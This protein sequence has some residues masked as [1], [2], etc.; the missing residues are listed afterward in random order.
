M[1]RAMKKFGILGIAICSIFS[2]TLLAQNGASD[3]TIMTVDGK[4]VPRSE[5]EAIYKKNN[6]ETVVTQKALDEYLDLFINYKLK[7]REAE[8]LGM[9]TISKF[10]T[11]LDGYRKQLS[12]PYLIDRELNDALMKEA[13][14]R[15]QQ[16]IRA[17][18][19]LLQVAPDASPEDTLVVYK[20]IVALRDRIVKGE[21]FASIAQ[22][23]G[24]SEDPSA[25]KNGGDLGWFSAL[26]MVYPFESA[27]YKTQVGEV[28][29]PVRTRFGYH[30][31]KV[32]DRRP[33]RG[34][35]KVA[36][37][38]MRSTDQDPADKQ[39]SVE[40]RIKEVYEQINTGKLTFADAALKFSEDESSNT[41]GG[42]LPMFGTGKM[43]EEFEDTAFGLQKPQDMSA[44]IKSRYGW[45][46]IRLL[47]KQPVPAFDGAKSELKNKISRDSRAEITQ[48]V[49]L[50]RLRKDLGY[51]ADIKNRKALIALID[52]N[53]YKKGTSES[54]TLLR[55]NVAEGPYEIKGVRYRREILGAI[56]AGKLLNAKSRQYDEMTQTMDDTVVVRSIMD[57]WNYDR[58]KAA[59]L[60]KPVFTFKGGTYSQ[61]DLLDHIEAKQRRERTMPIAE[62]VE[63]RFQE[64]AD[65]KIM[66][67]EDA[68]L[69]EKYPEF[70][71]LMKEYRDGILLFELTDQKVWG[72]AVRDTA[73]LEAYYNTHKPDFMWATRY[74]GDLYTCQ[75]VAVAKQVR[76]LL[77][78]GKRGAQ[79]TDVVNKDNAL[80]L[81]VESGLFTEEQKPFLKGITKPGLGPNVQLDDR[82]VITDIKGVRAP[83]PKTLDEARGLI[84]AAYQDSLEKAWIA[85]LRAKYPVSVDQDVLHSIK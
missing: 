37:I 35:V 45:H 21:D 34:Q 58:K 77:T 69:E 67:Y 11:E 9:D 6:K 22:G 16:E 24:G 63:M 66:A 85:E 41:K 27:A 70:R 18:H 57:G 26:Q 61:K 51:T 82:I 20:R 5:F 62:M 53:V 39:A 12:R 32:V 65:E 33:A 83:E 48:K 81:S 30:I 1:E 47:E 40:Q 64:F 55:K 74:E 14:E 15:M 68:H 13:Y 80:A 36:H 52:T 23:K 84:T 19:I 71:L 49:F 28:S 50:E 44:P 7:V 56:S 8:V 76:G 75:N 29:M 60:T 42:E 3:P 73:G 10:K 46:I 17:S 38:M 4:A 78:K 54:D 25:A 43:I 79:L 31:I 72:K 59:K 2:T